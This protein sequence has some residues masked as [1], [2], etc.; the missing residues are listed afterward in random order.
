[1]KPPIRIPEDRTIESIQ[2]AVAA[3]KS[4]YET[5]EN[6]VGVLQSVILVVLMVFVT[7]LS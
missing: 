5:I 1:V 4:F 7:W 2:N 6:L 3:V